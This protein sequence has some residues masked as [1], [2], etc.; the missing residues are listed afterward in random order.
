MVLTPFVSGQTARIYALKKRLF[1][2]EP[3]QTVNIPE[4][5]LSGH[6]VIAGGGRVGMQIASVL[7]GHGLRFVIVE[8]DQRRVEEAKVAGMP[9]IYG[10]STHEIVLKAAGIEEACLLL[11]T[12]PGLI[13]A[14]ATV[15][16]AQRL[17]PRLHIVSRAPDFASVEEFRQLAV[18]E[19]VLPEFETGLEMTRQALLHL[20]IPV[21]EIQR[22][23]DALRDSLFSTPSPHRDAYRTLGQLRGAERQFDL[24]WVAVEP[25]SSIVGKTLGEL[26]VRRLTGASVVGV[27][28]NG[29]LITNPGPEFTVGAEDLL[30]MIGTPETQEAFQQFVRTSSE[31][32]D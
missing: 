15:V 1:R 29:G 4:D 13:V 12:T 8:L 18:H 10:D 9:A 14:R 19:V 20:Q 26:E 25:R 11:V 6:V 22:T 23:T 21:P 32:H 27:L 17:N 5:G 3:L 24:Q 16:H 28:R 2:H 7:Q 30:A 31:I